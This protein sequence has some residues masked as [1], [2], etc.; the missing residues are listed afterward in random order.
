[1]YVACVSGDGSTIAT[2]EY[3]P[4][5]RTAERMHCTVVVRDVASATV[6]RVLQTANK[7][8]SPQLSADGR[9]L[10]TV[11]HGEHTFVG[12]PIGAS[13]VTVWDL[14]AKTQRVY[15]SPRAVSRVCMSADGRVLVTVLL[16]KLNDHGMLIGNTTVV[17]RRDDVATVDDVWLGSVTACSLSAD[18]E[19]FAFV[20]NAFT[21]GV[22]RTDTGEVRRK[23]VHTKPVSTTKL[24]PDGNSLLTV[25]HGRVSAASVPLDGSVVTLRDVRS[26]VLLA[27]FQSDQNVAHCA[28]G[29]DRVALVT[30]HKVVLRTWPAYARK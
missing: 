23:F 15:T 9:T 21:V 29:G 19:T 2:C 10:V 26:G 1:V 5:G 3:R 11:E 16:G 18:G 4:S 24:S 20:S 27:R 17:V 6:L 22:L 13:T 7:A 30:G 8:S 25:E 28:L 12:K 14:A